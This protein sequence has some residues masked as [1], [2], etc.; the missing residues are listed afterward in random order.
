[1]GRTKNKYPYKVAQILESRELKLV[2]KVCIEKLETD[3]T[4]LYILIDKEHGL[5]ALIANY[6]PHNGIT[7]NV[8]RC[9][10]VYIKLSSLKKLKGLN[11]KAIETLYGKA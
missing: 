11:F 10:I 7:R 4:D 6:E 8:Q 2:S 5:T 3:T 1:M 9:D